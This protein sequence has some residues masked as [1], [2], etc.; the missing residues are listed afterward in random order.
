MNFDYNFQLKILIFLI[1]NG[2]LR[3]SIVIFG[4]WIEHFIK[5]FRFPVGILQISILSENRK[6]F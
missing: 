6:K 3:I 2:I 1:L 4:I 5:I